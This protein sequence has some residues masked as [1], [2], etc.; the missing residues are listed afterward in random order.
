VTDYDIELKAVEEGTV[1]M[2]HDGILKALDGETT[3]DEIFR[4]AG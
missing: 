4:V 2:L 1:L 3:L